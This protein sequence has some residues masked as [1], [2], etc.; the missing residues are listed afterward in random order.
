MSS[1]AIDIIIL[2]II[3]VVVT[4]IAYNTYR[5]ADGSKDFL[6]SANAGLW[7]AMLIGGF[8]YTVGWVG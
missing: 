3:W 8:A 1:A 2:P 7:A 6:G 4:I 5:K